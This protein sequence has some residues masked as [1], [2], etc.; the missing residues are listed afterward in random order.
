MALAATNF[1]VFLS[2]FW[3]WFPAASHGANLPVLALW[4]LGVHRLGGR[5][6][7]G[8]FVLSV[9][10]MLGAM[11][12]TA[13]GWKWLA[14]GFY[15]TDGIQMQRR[16]FLDLAHSGR[17]P[18]WL[19]ATLLWSPAIA[20][21]AGVIEL[22]AQSL[23]LPAVLL[24]MWRPRCRLIATA[25]A[26][27]AATGVHIGMGI[28]NLQFIPL[29]LVMLIQPGRPIIRRPP[30]FEAAALAAI[31]I[32]FAVVA[33]LPRS[34]SKRHL[35]PFVDYPMFSFPQMPTEARRLRVTGMDQLD[36]VQSEFFILPT[37]WEPLSDRTRR[38]GLAHGLDPKSLVEVTY[39]F[40]DF[41]ADPRSLRTAP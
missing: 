17:P 14:S 4:A 23:A 18:T 39:H 12:T 20:R 40:D 21:I 8:C 15:W 6:M 7:P 33:A 2:I 24:A 11:F 32:V 19:G 16:V 28:Y 34:L 22:T 29:A 27:V 41:M 5:S 38:M 35:Y 13:A 26:L 36:F 25:P 37:A 1:T 3:S 30:G 9:Q 10:L 31:V